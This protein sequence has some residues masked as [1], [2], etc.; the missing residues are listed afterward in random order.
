LVFVTT[1]R[2]PIAFCLAHGAGSL[3]GPRSTSSGESITLEIHA[4]SSVVRRR[5][6]QGER[7]GERGGGR[8]MRSGTTRR[9]STENVRPSRAPIALFLRSEGP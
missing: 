1:V 7:E 4:A 5:G 9:S 8:A 2:G 6:R 3:M